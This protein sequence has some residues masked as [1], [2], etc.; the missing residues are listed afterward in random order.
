MA[1][2]RAM[3]PEQRYPANVEYVRSAEAVTESEGY[4]RELC[5]RTFLSLWSYPNPFRDQSGGDADGKEICDLLVVFENNIVI[6]SDKHCE[7][8]DSGNLDLDWARWYRR[9]IEKS[10]H[11]LWGAERWIRAHPDRV[12][13]DAKCTKKFPLPLTTMADTVFHRVVIAHG[14]SARCVRELGG[15]GSL[16]LNS[17]VV[18]GAHTLPRDKGGVPF[19]VGQVDT[20]KGYVHILDDTTFEILLM[21]LDTVAD[22]SAYLSKKERFIKS[23]VM[24]SA[25]GEEELLAYYLTHLNDSKEYDFV[26]KGDFNVVTLDEGFWQDFVRSPQRKRQQE[27]NNVSYI[28]DDIIERFTRHFLQG[29]SHFLS[30]ATLSSHELILRF[31]AR[32]PRVRRRMLASAIIDM[33]KTTPPHV[34]R[35]RMMK[36][37]RPGDPHFILLL[38][39]KPVDRSYDEYRGVRQ[40]YLEACCHVVKLEFPD[41]LNIV[42]FA[43]ETAATLGRSEDAVYFDA[44]QWTEEMANAARRDKEVLKILT[45]ATM[46][47]G[48]EYDYPLESPGRRSPAGDA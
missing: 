47:E 46:T 24:L 22:L 18:G 32:E 16:M 28:W 20:T 1:E 40:K 39:P 45:T 10:A 8:P 14:A 3:T 29:T 23:G 33:V 41:A 25:A 17:A 2:Q 31:F 35:L 26:F 11:Q 12:F 7:F 19:M 34:R 13:L 37:S 30:D 5:D 42:G 44:R 6:F 15:S 48:V 36:P 27:A 9:A 21:T 4:L 43:T 38:L